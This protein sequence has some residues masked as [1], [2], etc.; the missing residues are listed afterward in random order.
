MTKRQDT[1]KTHIC[2]AQDIT[3]PVL[4]AAV[5]DSSC[6]HFGSYCD[7]LADEGIIDQEAGTEWSYQSVGGERIP[8]SNQIMLRA[9]VTYQ[10]DKKFNMVTFSA[11]AA[12][13]TWQAGV[14]GFQMF[15]N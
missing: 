5:F 1:G 8:I 13:P 6:V 14:S 7:L 11:A 9:A 10:M 2:L 4:Q 12:L 15:L 3:S